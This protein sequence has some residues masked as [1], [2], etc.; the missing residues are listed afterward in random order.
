MT[1]VNWVWT[2]GLAALGVL[3]FAIGGVDKA[4]ATV[5]SCS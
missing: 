5:L 4:T 3:T 1:G 2:L